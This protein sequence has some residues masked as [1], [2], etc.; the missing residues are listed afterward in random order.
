MYKYNYFELLARNAIKIKRGKIKKFTRNKFS[1]AFIQILGTYKKHLVHTGT[2]TNVQNN[3][4]KLS[5]FGVGITRLFLHQEITRNISCR[6]KYL[7]SDNSF[8]GY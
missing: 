4:I 6:E 7:N 3:S 2:L 8:A 5:G 1:K